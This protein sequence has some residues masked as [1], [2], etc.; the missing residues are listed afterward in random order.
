MDQEEK[1]LIFI[2]Y[3]TLM[4]SEELIDEDVYFEIMQSL[5]RKR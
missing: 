4:Y 3:L 5:S 2:S 1:E